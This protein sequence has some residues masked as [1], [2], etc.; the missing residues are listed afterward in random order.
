M[1]FDPAF[2]FAL[3]AVFIRTSAMFFAA[4]VFGSSSVPVRVRILFAA[5]LALALFPVVKQHLPPPP[6]DLYGVL[7]LVANEALAG[8]IVGLFLSLVMLGIMMGGSIM[9]IQVGLSMSHVV[10]P[11]NGQASTLLSQFKYLLALIVFLCANGH[12]VLIIALAGS[13]RLMPVSGMGV[14]EAIK[15]QQ[16]YLLAHLSLIA[17]QIAVP[18]LAVT[19][20]VDAALG[21]M[22]RAVPQ[23]Q[24]FIVGLPAKVMMGLVA[25]SVGLPA[26]TTAVLNGVERATESMERVLTVRR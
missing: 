26:I 13:F 5:L 19:I 4:P 9:D 1:K 7:L 21:L 16:V 3:F 18:I 8:F 15:D 6:S 25:L 23:M 24:T 12:H 17:L 22:N 10:N 2:L 20:L 11:A 14:L